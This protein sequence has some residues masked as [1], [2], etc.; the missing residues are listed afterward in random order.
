MQ[1]TVY[2][3]KILLNATRMSSLLSEYSRAESIPLITNTRFRRKNWNKQR[4]SQKFLC[5]WFHS[6]KCWV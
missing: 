3:L 2:T 6:V 5:W 4:W 1:C